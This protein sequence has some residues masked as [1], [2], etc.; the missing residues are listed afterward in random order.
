M[1]GDL[2]IYTVARRCD[3]HANLCHKGLNP[4]GFG[5]N[6]SHSNSPNVRGVARPPAPFKMRGQQGGLGGL[7][8]TQNDSSP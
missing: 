7:T 6:L 3:L 2:K 4:R 1:L 8:G 5:S